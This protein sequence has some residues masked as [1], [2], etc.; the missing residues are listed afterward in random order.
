MHRS[1]SIFDTKPLNFAHRGYTVS[2]P[3]NTL[4][5][6]QAA[7]D[8]GVDG[9][10]FDVRTCKSGEVVVFHDSMLT[11]M[12]N[13]RGFVKNKTLAELKRLKIRGQNPDMNHPI[14]TLEEVIELVNG[15]A[16]LNVEIK[17]KGLPKDHI[18]GKVVAILRQYGIE[19]NTILSSFNPIV[20]R[21]IKKI[22]DEIITGF[23]MDKSFTVRYSEIPLTKLAGA[24]AIHLENNLAKDSFIR[25]IQALG[26][27]CVVWNVNNP[28]EMRRLIDLDVNGIITDRPGQ[29]KEIKFSAPHA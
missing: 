26:F 17:T 18:E 19:Y 22:D 7:L 8:L 27:Y 16:I 6:F 10:E 28:E 15:R 5:A 20:M 24:K 29:M 14:P 1:I 9:I 12:T 13:G 3:E 23:L 21:R 4:A 11:R 2:A 25:K